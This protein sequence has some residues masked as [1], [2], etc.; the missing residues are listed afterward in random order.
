MAFII[1]ILLLILLSTTYKLTLRVNKLEQLVQDLQP[2]PLPEQKI[3]A[4]VAKPADEEPKANSPIFARNNDNI[5]DE[6][7]FPDEITQ[8]ATIA[9]ANTKQAEATMSAITKTNWFA[10]LW[11]GNLVAKLGVLLLFIGA[12]FWAKY[13]IEH[14]LLSL[15]WRFTGVAVVAS[16]L[17]LLGLLWRRAP[18][19]YRLALQGGGLGLWYAGIFFSTALYH[20]LPTLVSFIA[21]SLISIITMIL[22][23]AQNAVS[24]V[25]LALLC[26]FAA[27]LFINIFSADQHL[28]LFSYYLILN[29]C[30]GVIVYRKPWRSV[31]L[32][33]F[34]ATFI[35]AGWWGWYQYQ[36]S[37]FISSEIFLNLFFALYLLLTIFFAYRYQPQQIYWNDSLVFAL[38]LFTLSLQAGLLKNFAY[39]FASATSILTVFYC[40]LG[41][42]LIKATSKLQQLGKEF[43]VVAILLLTTSIPLWLKNSD[44]TVVVWITESAVIVWSGLQRNNRFLTIFGVLLQCASQLY[45]LIFYFSSWYSESANAATCAL[46]ALVNFAIAYLLEQRKQKNWQQDYLVL[47]FGAGLF[48]LVLLWN[49]L[50][51][52]FCP[53]FHMLNRSLPYLFGADNDLL[54][55]TTQLYTI[56]VAAI[57]YGLNRVLRWQRLNLLGWCLFAVLFYSLAMN[58]QMNFSWLLLFVGWMIF[59][60]QQKNLPENKL[61]QLHGG[62]I[63]LLTLQ[64]I[65]FINH[66]FIA[67]PDWRITVRLLFMALFVGLLSWPKFYLMPPGKLLPKFYRQTCLGFLLALAELLLLQSVFGCSGELGVF[68]KLPILN[69]LD[70][71]SIALL[72]LGFWWLWQNQNWLW[73]NNKTIPWYYWSPLSILSLFWLSAVLMRTLHQWLHIP[74]A[75]MPMMQ[76]TIVQSSLSLLWGLT[77]LAIIIW[78]RYYRVRGLW[79][80]GIALLGLVFVKLLFIDLYQINTLGKVVTFIILGVLMLITGYFSPEPP[81]AQDKTMK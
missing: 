29:I 37:Y 74:W 56:E 40:L 3:E 70:L 36:S 35:L 41:V 20:L 6:T 62:S 7:A 75:I 32:L 24:L 31:F 81:V 25:V 65:I 67:Q 28:L 61:R 46:I 2:K 13:S 10:R 34:V 43:L 39:G 23:I 8:A 9:T 79:F 1:F 72:V 66:Q 11:Q 58:D 64:I 33:G 63:A 49:N 52:L 5:A 55:S 47:S 21:A 50:F 18:F 54:S 48:W 30:L 38:P 16:V 4:A 73:P 17:L 78:A 44:M 71:A 76:S 19:H 22:A 77:A 51:N 42:Y 69:P 53:A 26:A 59:L 60:C 80:A 68:A 57:I 15:T 12:S 14:N 27:P 45:F